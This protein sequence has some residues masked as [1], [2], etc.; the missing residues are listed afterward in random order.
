M[1]YSSSETRLYPCQ[2]VHSKIAT[3]Q[4]VINI[5]RRL[6]SFTLETFES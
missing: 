1:F 4:I 3:T 5:S 2:I 6:A